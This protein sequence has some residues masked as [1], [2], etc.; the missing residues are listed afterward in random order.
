MLEKGI[1]DSLSIIKRLSYPKHFSNAAK[2]YS[3]VLGVGGN[4]GDT[5][6]RL[7]KLTLYFQKDPR[8]SLHRTSFILKN[9]PFGYLDQKDFYNAVIL[10]STNL[11]PLK[12][13]KHLLHVEHLFGRKRSFK[14]AP[15]TMDIDMLFYDNRSLDTKNLTLPHPAWANRESVLLPLQNLGSLR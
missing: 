6:R 12:L 15:R 3:V 7:E 5:V 9:P 14:N 1:D 13:L 8:V 2:R 4:V 10:I 11:A